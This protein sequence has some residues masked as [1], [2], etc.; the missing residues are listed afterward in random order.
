M[1][2]IFPFVFQFGPSCSVRRVI[3]PY[4]QIVLLLPLYSCG[5]NATICLYVLCR[6]YTSSA[7][8]SVV[9]GD[10][11]GLHWMLWLG[12]FVR[13][14]RHCTTQKC[15]S[16]LARYQRTVSWKLSRG[17][18]KFDRA[19]ITAALY[20]GNKSRMM[21][22]TIRHGGP[23]IRQRELFQEYILMNVFAKLT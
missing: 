6:W 7:V 18:A 16:R 5:Y 14:N 19:E 15:K 4:L 13:I 23:W 3:S 8:N 17:T 10:R 22:L 21:R 20:Q 1:T 11:V 9:P 12:S 2:F